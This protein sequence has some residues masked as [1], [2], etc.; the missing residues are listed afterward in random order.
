MDETNHFSGI[1]EFWAQDAGMQEGMGPV[2][3]RTRE[4]LGTSDTAI[5]SVRR[6]LLR[7]AKALLGDEEPPEG[8]LHPEIYR[9]RGAA[10]L[11]APDADWVAETEAI[12]E[13]VPGVNPSAPSRQ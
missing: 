9:V 8:A 4:H 1:P 6:H 7:A 2:Y 3:D 13:F 10:A 11:L 12:R 5:M